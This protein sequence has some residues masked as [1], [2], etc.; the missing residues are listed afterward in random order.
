MRLHWTDETQ[1]ALHERVVVPSAM[2]CVDTNARNPR[3]PATEKPR[4]LPE[5]DNSQN[6]T[7]EAVAFDSRKFS[8]ECRHLS[9]TVSGVS[10]TAVGCG[11]RTRQ[12]LRMKKKKET[13]VLQHEMHDCEAHFAGRPDNGKRCRAGFRSMPADLE[14]RDVQTQSNDVN[15]SRVWQLFFFF[16]FC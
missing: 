7:M 6:G 5:E 9:L 16:S 14:T 3:K 15:V 1:T 2:P 4:E 12:V 11:R 13:A 10:R 8:A